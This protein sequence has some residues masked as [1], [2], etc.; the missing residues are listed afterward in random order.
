MIFTIM[1]LTCSTSSLLLSPGAGQI[2]AGVPTTFSATIYFVIML[3][4][5]GLSLYYMNFKW[6]LSW[7]Q[8]FSIPHYGFTAFLHND[9]LGQN[10]CP[11]NKT[12]EISRCQNSVTC[13]GEEYLTIQGIDLS[14][15]G[16]WKNHVA[17][18]LASE[19]ADVLYDNMSLPDLIERAGIEAVKQVMQKN[20]TDE[21][22]G[23]IRDKCRL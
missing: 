12:A 20:L 4:A 18:G 19:N 2:A 22:I 16:F 21:R 11:E 8:Y 6:F 13:T 10:F 7:I 14:S 17:L 1:M 5:S 9:L 3:F 23:E 15:W